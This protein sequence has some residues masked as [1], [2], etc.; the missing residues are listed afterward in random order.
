MGE[1]M[2]LTQL[3]GGIL[4]LIVIFLIAFA[5]NRVA[6]VKSNNPCVHHKYKGQLQLTDSINNLTLTPLDRNKDIGC[7]IFS[8]PENMDCNFIYFDN[9]SVTLICTSKGE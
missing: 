5:V 4:V 6:P 3:E 2:K 9:G 1:A 7:P 8:E